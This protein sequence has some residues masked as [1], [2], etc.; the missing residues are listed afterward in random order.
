MSMVGCILCLT[1]MERMRCVTQQPVIVFKSILTIFS[2]LS[3][4]WV[5]SVDI[6][7]VSHREAHLRRLR[8]FHSDSLMHNM[9]LAMVGTSYTRYSTYKIHVQYMLTWLAS[10]LVLWYYH[11]YEILCCNCRVL[12]GM[13]ECL[14]TLVRWP[15]VSWKSS[16]ICL[17]WW[18]S[19]CWTQCSCNSY[20]SKNTIIL[21][22]PAWQGSEDLHTWSTDGVG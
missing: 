22:P 21:L 4:F 12:L 19:P 7:V 9:V 8:W 10:M 11:C 2:T 13:R 14:G 20:V 15:C 17:M 5:L 3:A 6:V 1:D 16:E 18:V